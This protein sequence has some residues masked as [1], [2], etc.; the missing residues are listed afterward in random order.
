MNGLFWEVPGSS[1]RLLVKRRL[2]LFCISCLHGVVGGCPG[3]ASWR[4]SV[5]LRRTEAAGS[6]AYISLFCLRTASSNTN[7]NWL[8]AGLQ[9]I[10]PYD[11]YLY[12]SKQEKTFD[13]LHLR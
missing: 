10:D 11:L 5:S 6:L 7:M 8:V 4:I 13:L 2:V 3:D 9:G 1:N 12:S